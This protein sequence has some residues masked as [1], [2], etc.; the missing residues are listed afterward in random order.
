MIPM[1]G[2]E[3][4]ESIVHKY[5]VDFNT[6]EK[7]KIKA[8]GKAKK[9]SFK[10]VI[11]MKHSIPTE[12]INEVLSTA[13]ESLANRIAKRVVE[14][15]NNRPTNAVFVVGGGGQVKA[16]T[17]ALSKAVGLGEDRVV[18]RGKQVLGDIDFGELKVKKGPELVTPIGI[19]LT[20]LENNKHD[21]IQVFLNDEPI[22]IYDNN[23]LTVMDVA[24]YK[25]IDPKKLIARR[26]QAL[27]FTVNTNTR[28]IPG[29]A[30]TP[31]VIMV[32]SDEVNLTNPITMNDY[33]TIIE[34]KQGD[35]G[36]LSTYQLLQELNLKVYVDDKEYPLIP[37]VYVNDQL[38]DMNYEIKLND[39]IRLRLPSLDSFL[40]QYNLD[41]YNND[42]YIN[43]QLAEE[44]GASLADMDRIT[45]RTKGGAK[46]SSTDKSTTIEV[47]D[48]ISNSIFVTVNKTP[49]K[50]E[51]KSTYVFVDIFEVYPFDLSKPQGN[52]VCKIND[53]KASY[54]GPIN[55]GDTLEVFWEPVN[56]V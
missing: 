49:V 40:I 47:N 16:F 27:E 31:A 41:D 48:K 50:L 11:G 46:T 51:G 37:H 6:A 24:A 39:H 19:C 8:S 25:G 9:V 18:M 45:L 44:G 13:V 26:G 34:A 28:R 29:D 52:V 12:E 15:N 21:F 32:N 55:E 3:L 42:F 35:D 17:A 2:D 22:K 4:T 54:M 30:G 1:A 5:L 38:L 33:I 20:G 7:I 14:L 53:E 36:H 43:G 23:R 56:K 10:D